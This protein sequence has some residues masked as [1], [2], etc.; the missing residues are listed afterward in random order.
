MF[1]KT[2]VAM[3]GVAVMMPSMVMAQEATQTQQIKGAA[4]AEKPII[5]IPLFANETKGHLTR[6]APGKYKS[7]VKTEATRDL[8]VDA[9]A[10]KSRYIESM[11][12]EFAPGEW[13]LPEVAAE[14]A[15]DA[16]IA[17]TTALNRFRVLS[18]STP[19]LRMAD[20]EIAFQG[21]SGSVEA[22]RLFSSLRSC[23]AKYLLLGRINRFRVDETKGEAYG[24]RRWQ[25]VTSVS[26]DLQLIDVQ[27]MEVISSLPMEEK[28]AMRIPEGIDTVT[29][30]YD[31]EDVM[32]T[33]I[34]KTV[35][36]FFAELDVVP[37]A[38]ELVRSDATVEVSINSIPEGA[39]VEFDGDFMGNTPCQVM[40]PEKRGTLTIS[41][42]GY[43]PWSRQVK[44]SK[45]I[46]ISPKLNPIPVKPSQDVDAG[47]AK[48]EKETEE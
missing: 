12:V 2:L 22:S 43:E 9:S 47:K 28:L 20:N 27:S 6:V 19:A 13:R 26:L 35:P 4:R 41:A 30:I 42:A 11:D 45:G 18:R 39:D 32:R 8:N 14:V 36:R 37:G 33:A 3:L 29:S 38:D 25:I 34:A 24:V 15:T 21:T 1:I 16:A 31:W 44:P 5:A 23:N 17:A 48:P 7:I 40:L 46:V 10:D